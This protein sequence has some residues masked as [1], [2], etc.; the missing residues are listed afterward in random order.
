MYEMVRN[1]NDPAIVQ[2]KKNCTNSSNMKPF[3][4]IYI[5]LIIGVNHM[6]QANW[7]NPTIQD[8]PYMDHVVLASKYTLNE[9]HLR[10]TIADP[11]ARN[12]STTHICSLKISF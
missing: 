5:L 1:N 12:T 8:H 6:V 10:A 3:H 11:V 7:L 9:P 2:E 4:L